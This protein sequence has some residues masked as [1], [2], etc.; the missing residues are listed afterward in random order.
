VTV[1]FNQVPSTL[2]VP[3]VYAEFDPSKANQGPS[4]QPYQV[5]V[6]GQRLTTGT[7][8]ALTPTLVTSEEQAAEYFG[9]GSQLHGIARAIFLNNKVT[10][11][12]FCALA[13][14]GG[15][16]AATGTI[17]ITG[18]ATAAGTVY[19]YVAG[20]RLQIA[21]ASGDTA[22]TVAAA[23][24]AAITAATYLPFTAAAVAGVVTLTAR[25]KGTAANGLDVRTNYY[26]DER[27]PAGI[28][29][30]IVLP[31]G[32]SGDP[33]I[34]T[35]WAVLGDEHYNVFVCP[36]TNSANLTALHTEL[37]DRFGPMRAIEG[38]AFLAKGDSH[39]NLITFGDGLNSPHLS[40]MAFEKSPTPGYEWAAA[41]AAVVALY[42]NIDPAR[43]FQTL[44]LRG[45]LAPT[46]ADR[47]TREERNLLLYDGLSTFTVDPDGTVRCERLLTT[48]QE[49]GFGAADPSYL[50][51]PTLLTLGYL[52]YD[53][54]NAFL[55]QFPRHKLADDG[56]RFGAGQAVMTPKVGRAFAISKFGQWES[57]GLVENIDQFKRDLI[58]E[59]D[60]QNPN[61]LNFLLPPDLV[62]QLM[63]TAVQIGF[64]LSTSAG[65]A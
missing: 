50:D 42:G 6:L 33:D 5:L 39:A 60:A 26:R 56:V 12:T 37:S 49:N 64:R 11:M 8:A 27:T 46:E 10:K 40:V 53:F 7:V 15:S 18:P 59:R 34:A 29:V 47:F 36:W 45:V 63:I 25:N 54:V 24:A 65:V 20:H 9:E 16:V 14:A 52:R 1:S 22:T 30:A 57:L 13:D 32:G 17:T 61:R 28:A 3:F 35:A 44:P 58:V 48:Y 31:S 2:R 62:N 41:V 23:I 51:V 43:P 19:L 55:L 38:L 21:V 4:I